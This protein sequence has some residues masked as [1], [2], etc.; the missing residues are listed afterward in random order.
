MYDRKIEEK[1][2][3]FRV[4]GKLWM[5]SLVMSDVETNTEWSHLLGRAMAGPLMSKTLDPIVADMLTWSAWK[6]KH[7]DTTVL[8]MSRTAQ[9][10]TRDFYNKEPEKYVLGFRIGSRSHFIGLT[11]LIDQPVLSC[12]IAQTPLL[13]AF[14]SDGAVVR[15]FNSETENRSLTFRPLES[16]QMQDLQ[17]ESTW[18]RATGEAIA[19]ELKGTKLRQ[20]IGIMSYRTAWLNFHPGTSEVNP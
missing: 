8:A 2:L 5:R 18:N 16:N 11:K 13:L 20:R 12:E 9:R 3:T 4:S 6:K 1:T 17:T 14:D 19:G 15:L 7:P 10:F